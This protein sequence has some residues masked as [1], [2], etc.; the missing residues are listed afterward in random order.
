MPSP[1]KRLAP[2]VPA[3]NGN[4][5]QQAYAQ[6]RHAIMAGMYKPGE[7]LTLR[8]LAAA[9]GT[10]IIPAR[11][12]VLRLIGEQALERAGRGVRIPTLDERK[13]ADVLAFRIALEGEAA[14]L[15]ALRRTAVH[16]RVIE[17]MAQNAERCRLVGRLEPYMAA[18]Q[19]FHF[20]IY[21]A[22]QNDLLV[23]MIETLWLQIGPH[24]ASMA[25]GLTGS[26]QVIDHAPHVA[27]IQ[28]IKR[29]DA[30]AAR[31][32]LRADLIAPLELRAAPND[33][34]EAPIRKRG[35]GSIE[36]RSAL[37]SVG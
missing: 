35:G 13:V 6:L 1:V 27:L 7:A 15:A 19:E 2:L 22:A 28:A 12:A 31:T 33:A 32:A 25:S 4:L 36:G 5:H 17:R 14:A 26:I 34:P 11:D 18:N 23:S 3:E 9:L 29:G 20:A 37:G 10:S 21:R 16:L 8:A 30:D 24:L